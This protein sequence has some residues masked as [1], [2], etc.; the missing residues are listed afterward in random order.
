MSAARQPSL[1]SGRGDPPIENGVV[2]TVAAPHISLANDSDKRPEAGPARGVAKFRAS[3][4][5]YGI[6]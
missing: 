1:R 2:P 6:V 5:K 4:D 3:Y